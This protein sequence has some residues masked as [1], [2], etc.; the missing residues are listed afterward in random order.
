[1]QREVAKCAKL[2][3]FHSPLM[4]SMVESIA[5]EGRATHGHKPWVMVARADS[6][7]LRW[8]RGAYAF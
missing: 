8:V 6:W 2:F 5:G 4:V 1:M 3:C 7:N